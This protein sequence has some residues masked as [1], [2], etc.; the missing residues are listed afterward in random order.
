MDSSIAKKQLRTLMRAQRRA[1]GRGQRRGAALRAAQHFIRQRKFAAARR[2]AL[3]LAHGAELDPAPLADCLLRA[4]R[5]L[6]A[7]RLRRDGAMH[8]V[9]LQAR[10]P[11]R[12]G[13]HGIAAPAGRAP[14]ALLR[15]LDLIL[16]P[17]LAFDRAGR[18]LGSGGGSYDRLLAAR[19]CV[20][21]P[22]LVGYAHSLQEQARLPQDWWDRRLDAV[23]TERGVVW[24]NRQEESPAPG[25][26]RNPAPRTAGSVTGRKR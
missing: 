24:F 26:A 2:V 25:P 4:G 9:R 16:L 5:R 17:L 12:R 6:Y 23:V 21:R 10:S 7:P 13:R 15:R 11:L 22:L 19:R 1:L 18:R 3:Y 20:R 8:L 14:R